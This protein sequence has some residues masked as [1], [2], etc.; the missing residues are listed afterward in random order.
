MIAMEVKNN[1]V[2]TEGSLLTELRN[3]RESANAAF[4]TFCE[5]YRKYHEYIFC[6]Y[7]GEDGKYYNQRIKTVL[8]NII[9]PIKSGNKC[10]TLKAWRKIK[11]D[12]AYNSVNK[13]FFV[14]RDMDDL[15]EDI[16]DDLYVTPCYSV[17]NLYVCEHSF[18]NI[19]ESE[20]SISKLDRDYEK[21]IKLF[22]N[23]YTQFCEEMVEFN[24]LVYIR[25]N[26]QLGNGKIN[27]SGIKTSQLINI[28][29]SSVTKGSKYNSLIDELKYEMRVKPKEIETSINIIQTNGDYG[30]RF[31]GKNQLDFMVI[32]IQLLKQANKN[33][34]FFE[35]KQN[36]VSINITC[37]RLSELSQYA[38]TPDCLIEF[39][40]KHKP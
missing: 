2:V 31:R 5:N 35:N 39:I 7:E 19:I 8:G 6:F 12:S 13:M 32:L 23:L 4:I 29:L 9:I 16:N 38:E 22:T 17:E 27:L 21:C 26:K 40:K 28:D 18:A 37:N 24:A 30:N 10:N 1:C 11:K 3:S 34:Y 25:K 15:P 36:S 20:F 33:G 14:D